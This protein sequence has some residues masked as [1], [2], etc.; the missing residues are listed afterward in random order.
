[1]LSNLTGKSEVSDKDINLLHVV[2]V[3]ELIKTRLQ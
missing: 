2:S 1:M 3:G